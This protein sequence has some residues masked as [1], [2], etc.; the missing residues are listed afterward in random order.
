MAEVSKSYDELLDFIG[1]EQFLSGCHSHLAMFLREQKP[2]KGKDIIQYA[3]RYL[4]AHGGEISQFY[5]KGNLKNK[6]RYEQTTRRQGDQM[7]PVKPNIAAIPMEERQCYKC[8]EMGHIAR[9]CTNS[10]VRQDTRVCYLCDKKGHIAKD[11]Q[12]LNRQ[13]H[14]CQ[15]CINI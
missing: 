4:E 13:P 2:K 14:G 5:D 11:C 12:A 9:D 15:C 1:R 10:E 8:R 7:K 6:S 3:E